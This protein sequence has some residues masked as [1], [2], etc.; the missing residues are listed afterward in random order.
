MTDDEIRQLVRSAIARH[1]GPAS[2]ALPV[3]ATPAPPARA[4]PIAFTRYPLPRASDDVMCIIEPAVRCTHCG[5]CEC[6][7]H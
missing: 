7:G 2:S 6:H 4:V 3:P 1:L 5:Y